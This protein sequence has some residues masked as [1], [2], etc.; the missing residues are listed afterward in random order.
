MLRMFD[1]FPGCMFKGYSLLQE[2]FA[3]IFNGKNAAEIVSDGAS[4]L[5]TE[6][7]MTKIVSRNNWNMRFC[8]PH[9]L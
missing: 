5:K 8:R 3:E 1:E 7:I 4:T 2:V 9:K 6:K